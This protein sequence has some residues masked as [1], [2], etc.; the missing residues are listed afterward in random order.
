MLRPT[1]R[2]DDGGGVVDAR[3]LPDAFRCPT[4]VRASDS[5]GN[6]ASAASFSH[7]RGNCPPSSARCDVPVPPAQSQV[8]L[9]PT[10]PGFADG[11][12]ATGNQIDAAGKVG[13]QLEFEVNA[14]LEGTVEE[15]ER[16]ET[17]KE[18]SSA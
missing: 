6:I 4:T 11:D 1:V 12:P 18:G 9:M 2:I 8:T 13:S 15:Q 3:G 7:E 14:E 10:A 5:D 17:K 16:N